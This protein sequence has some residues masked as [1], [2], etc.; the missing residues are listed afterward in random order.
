M[1]L[2][3]TQ[4]RILPAFK[5]AKHYGVMTGV[6]TPKLGVKENGIEQ[7]ERLLRG[8]SQEDFGYMVIAEPVQDFEVVQA[9]DDIA[10]L[11]KDQTAL[12]TETRQYVK[13]SRLS[14][15]ARP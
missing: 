12:I 9:F 2:L 11:I 7:I 5:K 15:G 13:T 1:T 3:E 6:P 14:L 10:L 8:V 4:K